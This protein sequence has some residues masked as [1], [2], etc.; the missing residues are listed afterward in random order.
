M[1]RGIR[2]S[3]IKREETINISQPIIQTWNNSTERICPDQVYVPD[4]DL[5]LRFYDSDSFVIT[6]LNDIVYVANNI[7]HPQI[8]MKLGKRK[9]RDGIDVRL[10]RNR[11]ILTVWLKKSLEEIILS[12]F[13]IRDKLLEGNYVYI[14]KIYRRKE[15]STKIDISDY[16]FV[17]E[18]GRHVYCY[19]FDELSIKYSEIINET[20]D[21][22][23]TQLPIFHVLSPLDKIKY[24][25]EE[26]KHLYYL[27]DKKYWYDKI[28]N[29]DVAEYHLLMYEE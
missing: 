3:I 18:Y 4:L 11:K 13:Q 20:K 10:W 1:R 17:F 5:N 8:Y 19:T 21:K 28:G 15:D 29:M 26:E 14:D 7:T 6:Y 2:P 12:L 23:L 24:Q 27:E 25:N 9:D 16:S 22:D